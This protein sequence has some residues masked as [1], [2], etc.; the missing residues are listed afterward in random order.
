MRQMSFNDQKSEAVFTFSVLMAIEPRPQR[1]QRG[2]RLNNRK[3]GL[4]PKQ[5]TAAHMGWGWEVK[6]EVLRKELFWLLREE[7]VVEKEV[8]TTEYSRPSVHRGEK[9]FRYLCRVSK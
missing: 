2:V 3:S 7:F 9:M 5:L 8:W 6:T 1:G 4:H